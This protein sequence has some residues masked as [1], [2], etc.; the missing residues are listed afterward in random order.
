MAQYTLTFSRENNDGSACIDYAWISSGRRSQLIL[1]QGEHRKIKT[2][3]IKDDQPIVNVFALTNRDKGLDK[4]WQSGNRPTR[5]T[6]AQFYVNSSKIVRTI[7]YADGS[8]QQDSTP[9]KLHP[10]PCSMK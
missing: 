6:L 2:D 1:N 3:D 8:S 9:L 4:A 5:I 10:L 7:Y